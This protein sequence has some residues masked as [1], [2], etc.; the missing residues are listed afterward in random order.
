MER[1]TANQFRDKLK[2]HV[3]RAIN[4]HEPL[5][6]TRR[7]GGDFVVLSLADFEAEQETLFVLKDEKLMSQIHRSMETIE[8][9]TG[10]VVAVEEL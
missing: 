4:N 2:D 1:T 6:V 10:R 8:K 3:D 9:G 5:H 7:R